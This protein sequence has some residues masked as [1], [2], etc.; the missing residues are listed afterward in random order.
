MNRLILDLKT[1]LDRCDDP[2]GMDSG[3]FILL[4]IPK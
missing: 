1:K 2:P 3:Q 4:K